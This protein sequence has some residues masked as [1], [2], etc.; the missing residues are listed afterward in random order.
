MTPLVQI[1]ALLARLQSG[2]PLSEVLPYAVTRSW[3]LQLAELDVLFSCG[4][5]FANE[6]PPQS[7][8]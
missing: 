2:I 1:R 5:G 7:S 4:V 8:L 6:S 3:H